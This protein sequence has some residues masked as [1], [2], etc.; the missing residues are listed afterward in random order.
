MSA[1]QRQ[2]RSGAY[3]K[4]HLF[5]RPKLPLL[6]IVFSLFLDEKH[7]ARHRYNKQYSNPEASAPATFLLLIIFS[8]FLVKNV[9]EGGIIINDQSSAVI[10]MILGHWALI[11]Y[12]LGTLSQLPVSEKTIARIADS[13]L[14]YPPVVND[15][16]Y[17]STAI[18]YIVF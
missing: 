8:H 1:E 13:R 18:F 2:Q 10:I 6:N 7:H 17:Y 14:N 4:G 11:P 9:I 5:D 16:L 15:I 12:F 3:Y